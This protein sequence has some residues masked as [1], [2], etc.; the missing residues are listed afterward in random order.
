MVGRVKG[1]TNTLIIEIVGRSFRFINNTDQ[2]DENSLWSMQSVA[3][4]ITYYYCIRCNLKPTI[5]LI[6]QGMNE[7]VQDD[8]NNGATQPKR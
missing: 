6:D 4:K 5:Y 8:K 2:E 7:N 3:A 1:T